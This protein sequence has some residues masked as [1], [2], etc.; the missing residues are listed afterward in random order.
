MTDYS[1]WK[2]TDLKAELKRR[3]I[4]QTGLRVKQNYIDRLLEADSAAQPEP[5]ADAPPPSNAPEEPTQEAS[6]QKGQDVTDEKKP[7]AEQEHVAEPAEPKDQAPTE[8]PEPAPRQTEDTVMKD[9][10]EQEGAGVEQAAEV[11]Q[12]LSVEAKGPTQELET[13]ESAPQQETATEPTEPKPAPA[14]PS[15]P[16]EPDSTTASSS[17][18]NESRED[19]IDDSKKR[20]RRSQSPPPSPRTAALKKAKA[21]DGLPRVVL[22]EDGTTE[23]PVDTEEAAG[24]AISDTTAPQDV[25]MQTTGLEKPQGPEES[26]TAARPG[27]AAA[28]EPGK[29]V[30]AAAGPVPS[31]RGEPESEKTEEP[32]PSK[33]ASGDARFKSLFPVANGGRPPSPSPK[34]L[35]EEEDEDRIVSPALHPATTSLYIRNFMRPLQPASL[36][37]HL[38]SLATPPTSSP[39]P[40]IILDFFLDSIKTHCFV[41]FTNVSAAS[42]V[43]SALHG[44]IWPDER[45]RKPLW[46]DFIPEEK[47]KEWIGIEQDSGNGARGAPRWEVL[48]DETDQG[49]KA[50]LQEASPTSQV[51][52]RNNR[53][54]NLNLGREPPLGPRATHGPMRR[55]SQAAAPPTAPA[56]YGGESF[57]A[58][59]D[60]FLSTTAKPK[61]YYQPVPRE[62]SDKRL[63]RFAD[64]YKA[65]PVPRRGGDEMRKYTFEETD[66]FVDK[67]PEYGGRGRRRGGRRR[68]DFR[69]S[70]RR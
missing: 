21:E 43:R 57:R 33:H 23:Q 65:G 61:L 53:D 37:H 60:R 22:K 42:R 66:F 56:R 15:A 17:E 3:G 10:Q 34:T 18:K 31:P 41:S 9:T 48:Y 54:T 14:V 28:Q 11:A 52:A 30:D 7:A 58:L 32:H 36:K 50:T 24:P 64:L 26:E 13:Q 68:G 35:A 4:P 59:D 6:E 47:V 5:S 62:V 20:K 44:T 38:V 29:D 69:D 51:P 16:Q 67:G 19:S 55:D 12:D 45:M 27:P 8:T 2:V 25:E 39:D 70:W 63:D 1:S 40:D 49:I 46:V